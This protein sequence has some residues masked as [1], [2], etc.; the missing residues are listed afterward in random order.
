MFLRILGVLLSTIGAAGFFM[1]FW[2]GL[3]FGDAYELEMPLTEI[4]DVV[5][6]ENGDLYFALTF[7]SRV[8]KYSSDGNFEKNFKINAVGGFFCLEII[9]NDLVV[10]VARRGVVDRYDLDGNAI[11]KNNPFDGYVYREKCKR[12]ERIVDVKS[13]LEEVTVSL[14]DAQNPIVIERQPWHFIAFGPFISWLTFAIGLF[15]IPEWRHPIFSALTRSRELNEDARPEG[16]FLKAANI[17][18]NF[19][20]T[21]YGLIFTTIGGGM[22]LYATRIDDAGSAALTGVLGAL[23]VVSSI[24]WIYSI[25]TDYDSSIAVAPGIELDVGPAGLVAWKAFGLLILSGFIFAVLYIVESAD[26]AT[27]LR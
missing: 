23:F 4:S 15:L 14:T 12:S 26:G 7:T 10:Y 22:V 17:V 9:E 21:L 8:Q 2:I 1:P 20:Y 25:W 16:A 19:L 3:I 6:S 24:R 11:S 18:L 13:T 27:F 5:M